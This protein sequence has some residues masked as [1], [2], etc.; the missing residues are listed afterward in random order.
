MA[1]VAIES[2]SV[3][4]PVHVKSAKALLG[5]LVTRRPGAQIATGG[6]EHNVLVQALNDV[7]ITLE[8]GDRLGLLGHNG[9]GKTTFLRVCAGIYRPSAGLVTVEGR[10]AT[11]F[12]LTAGMNWEETGRANISLVLQCLGFTAAEIRELTKE[13]V[14]FSELGPFLD[15]PI[16]TYSAGMIARLAFSIATSP[17]PDV[18]L[19]DEVIGA[20]DAAF[21]DRARGRLS[22]LI[23][24]SGVL[25]LAS[26]ASHLVR[27]MCNKIAVF[28][29]GR[30]VFVGGVDEGFDEYDRIMATRA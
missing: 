26:H 6:N 21:F 24:R 18:L 8:N 10:I 23:G 3:S 15:M 29:A 16:R 14:S 2:V 13:I 11:I 30:L 28:N 25:V 9:S 17:Q 12:E 5:N 20:G 7:S 1:R 22:E 27:D 19:I 4:F